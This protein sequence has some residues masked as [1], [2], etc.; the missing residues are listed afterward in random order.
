MICPLHAWGG[1]SIRSHGLD[2]PAYLLG[3]SVVDSEDV[4]ATREVLESLRPTNGKRHWHDLRREERA[5]AVCLERLG[6]EL[7]RHDVSLLTLES[8]ASALIARDLRVV[9]ALRGRRVI[10]K[11]LRVEHGDPRNE[12]MLWLPD[13]LLGMFGEAMTTGKPFS[14]SITVG[15]EIFEVRP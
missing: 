9:E 2:A 8:R 6:W 14:D 1:E 5:R 11:T 7:A 10:P 13:Q 4:E 12:P 3:A 15:L